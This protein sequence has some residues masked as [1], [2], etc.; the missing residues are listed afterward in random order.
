MGSVFRAQRVG[1]GQNPSKDFANLFEKIWALSAKRPDGM[2][3]AAEVSLAALIPSAEA[4]SALAGLVTLL[5]L[6]DHIDA[7]LAAHDLAIAMTRLQRAERVR[8][9]HRSSPCSRRVRASE[10]NV[11]PLR[12]AVNG[13]RY[14]DRTS[15]HYDVNV[16]LYR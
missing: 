7:A 6:V 2:E 8:N 9:L 3:K 13:G 10:N 15:G 11:P 12:E 4:G 5:R 16:V 14:W 1:A